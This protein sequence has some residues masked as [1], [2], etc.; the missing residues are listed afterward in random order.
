MQVLFLTF[1]F[2]VQTAVFALDVS[3]KPEWSFTY[4]GTIHR[5]IPA[6]WPIESKNEPSADGVRLVTTTRAR[7]PGTG[8]EMSVIETTYRDLPVV[9]WTLAFENRG[10]A[11]TPRFTRITP[12]DFSFACADDAKLTLWRGICESKQYHHMCHEW[13]FFRKNIDYFF[14]TR[15]VNG[16]RMIDRRKAVIDLAEQHM[17]KASYLLDE[18]CHEAEEREFINAWRQVADYL[19]DGDYYLLTPEIFGDDCWW[20]TEF[21]N[22][23]GNDGFLQVVRNPK[24]ANDVLEVLPRG[25]KVGVRYAVKDLFSGAETEFTGGGPLA[26]R[27]PLDSGTLLKFGTK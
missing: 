12:G 9:E 4:G 1:A 21:K 8:L 27:L 10:T 24:T 3:L 25:V 20:V 22:P 15:I 6:G 2:G 19:I 11:D 17:T 7:E 16:Q 13:M 5:G 23:N 26:L 14:H 18:N